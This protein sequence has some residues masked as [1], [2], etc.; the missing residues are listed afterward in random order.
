MKQQLIINFD[1]GRI[2]IEGDFAGDP[3]A[4]MERAKFGIILKEMA[5]SPIAKP[6]PGQIL[7]VR[8]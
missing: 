1:D 4:L 3:V 8:K 5:P 7:E 6:T 2:S